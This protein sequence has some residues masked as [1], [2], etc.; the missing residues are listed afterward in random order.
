MVSIISYT[1]T[2]HHILLYFRSQGGGDEHEQRSVPHDGAAPDR[3]FPGFAPHR[4]NH[5]GLHPDLSIAGV[6]LLER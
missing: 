1:G 2:Y 3:E 5:G 6:N 4:C